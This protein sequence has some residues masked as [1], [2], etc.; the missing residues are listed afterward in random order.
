[1]E[2]ALE[3]GSV[4]FEQW[5]LLGGGMVRFAALLFLSV[6]AFLG[7]ANRFPKSKDGKFEQLR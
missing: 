1:M 4:D 5:A 2:D 3:V 6:A 7:E